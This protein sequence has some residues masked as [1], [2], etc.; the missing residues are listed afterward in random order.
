MWRLYKSR[1]GFNLG[2]SEEI[3]RTKDRNAGLFK[4]RLFGLINDL[5][6]RGRL[7]ARCSGVV[8]TNV[9]NGNSEV[10]TRRNWFVAHRGNGIPIEIFIGESYEHCPLRKKHM[11]LQGYE[12]EFFNGTIRGIKFP[13]PGDTEIKIKIR[14]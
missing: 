13:N 2:M 6:R 12:V 14:G 10:E 5:E 1:T 9:L 8:C 3:L 7:C 4:P 11:H